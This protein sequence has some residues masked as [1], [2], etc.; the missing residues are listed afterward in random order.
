MI[1]LD[2]NENL[3]LS[4]QALDVVKSY[5]KKLLDGDVPVW[6][7][8]ITKRLSKELTDYSQNVSQMIAGKQLQQNGF[9]VY[10]GK[11][12]KF[13][14]TSATNKRQRRIKS[15]ELIDERTNHDVMKY[16]FLLYSAASNI[17]SPF[18]YSIK[19]VQDYVKGT[20]QINMSFF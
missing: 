17:M 12:I 3:E 15:K 19:D 13:L 9:E 8:I 5:R 10:A 16:L 1:S 2:Y 7:L 11:S 18:N 4:R 6:D 14:F 20:K